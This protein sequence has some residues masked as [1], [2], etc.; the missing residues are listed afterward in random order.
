MNIDIGVDWAP[1]EQA[2][3]RMPEH[4]RV[5]VLY[6]CKVTADAVVREMHARL[7]RQLSSEATGKTVAGIHVVKAYDGNG[8]VILSDRG[9]EQIANLPLWLE[10][11]TRPGKRRNRARTRPRPFFYASIALEAGAHERRLIDAMREAAT[12]AGLGE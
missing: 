11:G 9:D 6:A 5:R 1:L 7:S 8:Y 10:K 2:I 3:T 12:D 4:L